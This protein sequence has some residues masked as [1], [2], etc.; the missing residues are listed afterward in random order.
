MLEQCPAKYLVLQQ[1]LA[2]VLVMAACT[3]ILSEGL[4]DI[5]ADLTGSFPDMPYDLAMKMLAMDN[6]GTGLSQPCSINSPKWGGVPG[7]IDV[8]ALA[9]PSSL[10]KQQEC[11]PS[12]LLFDTSSPSRQAY[13]TSITCPSVKWTQPGVNASMVRP[14]SAQI[15][16]HV[17][18]STWRLEPSQRP[19]P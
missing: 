7:A 8:Q 11:L 17:Y 5:D 15:Y 14:P 10:L 2:Q 16:T 9:S 18:E 6:I 19:S 4:R 12:F 1:I 13:S 3:C